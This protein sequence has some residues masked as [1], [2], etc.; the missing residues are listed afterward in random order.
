MMYLEQGQYDTPRVHYEVVEVEDPRRMM[1]SWDEVDRKLEIGDD[2]GFHESYDYTLLNETNHVYRDVLKNFELPLF[3]ISKQDSKRKEVRRKIGKD[4]SLHIYCPAGWPTVYDKDLL[5]FITGQVTHLALN[6]RATVHDYVGWH[7]SDYL[8]ATGRNRGGNNYVQ[9]WQALQRLAHFS[10]EIRVGLAGNNHHVVDVIRF[11]DQAQV[12]LSGGKMLGGRAK[13][14]GWLRE[15]IEQHRILSIDP[16]YYNL[17]GGVER[18][19]YEIA[20]HK[21][22]RQGSWK[23]NL[24]GL[25]EMV[26]SFSPFRN[27][28]Y[29]LREIIKKDTLPG[30]RWLITKDGFAL[31]YDRDCKKALGAVLRNGHI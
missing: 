14:S 30:Y 18:R 16:G 31:A 29:T 27:F 20:R 25:H 15:Q 23:I 13:I 12:Q 5:K 8:L 19:L 9:A 22:G 6:K 21:C 28:L 3:A 4:R 24:L 26:G 11:I 1:I 17:K 10:A 7:T 2:A